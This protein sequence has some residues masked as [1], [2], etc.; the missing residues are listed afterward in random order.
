MP[1][2]YPP[3][4]RYSHPGGVRSAVG[5]SPYRED[6]LSRRRQELHQR[7]HSWR[8]NLE[9][10]TK[11]FGFV[12]KL[13]I[14]FLNRKREIVDTLWAIF[15]ILLIFAPILILESLSFNIPVSLGTFRPYYW[16]G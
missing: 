5:Q 4:E 14:S 15:K 1:H 2:S 16:Y 8:R 11:G 3:S 6:T 7:Q 13:C 10:W 9:V 12:K